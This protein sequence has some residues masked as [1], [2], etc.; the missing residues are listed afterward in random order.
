MHTVLIKICK[1]AEK[2][3]AQRLILANHNKELQE[4]VIRKKTKANKKEGNL[5]PKDARVYNTQSLMERAH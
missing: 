5:S 4:A 1:A 3:I 2:T